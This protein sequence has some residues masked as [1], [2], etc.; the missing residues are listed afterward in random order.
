MLC[1]D[2]GRSDGFCDCLLTAAPRDGGGSPEAGATGEQTGAKEAQAEVTFGTSNAWDSHDTPEVPKASVGR[3]WA[4]SLLEFLRDFES[5]S[6][7]SKR[8]VS[9][10]QSGPNRPVGSA[11]LDLD[12][13][14]DGPLAAAERPAEPPN[15]MAASPHSSFSD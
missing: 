14:E 1:P 2:C 9:A 4:G 12:L 5:A 10:D 6:P 13:G 11:P 3:D 8:P 15:P 7:Q